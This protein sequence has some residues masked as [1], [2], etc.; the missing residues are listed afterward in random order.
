[1]KNGENNSLRP[2]AWITGTLCVLFCLF[3]LIGYLIEGIQKNDGKFKMPGDWLGV[4]T[5]VFIF[6]GLGGLI[7]AYWR[8][9]TGGLISL[10][11]FI[12]A[13]IFLIADPQLNFSPIFFLLYLP[14]FLY[15]AYWREIRK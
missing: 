13:T 11:A 9:G 12:L 6:I 15:L 2:A 8:E 14:T 1:M 10:I 3:G 4:A 7:V 5:E